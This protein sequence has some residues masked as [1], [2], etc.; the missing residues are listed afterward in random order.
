M[1]EGEKCIWRNAT[2]PEYN[3]DIRSDDFQ[4]HLV[5]GPAKVGTFRIVSAIL[6]WTAGENEI[7]CAHAL[8]VLSELLHQQLKV[9][10]ERMTASIVMP[11]VGT[12]IFVQI[13]V[14]LILRKEI[15]T[16]GDGIP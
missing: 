4:N 14:V 2:I 5:N 6:T 7:C 16:L 9:A 1:F 12:P 15:E 13:S 11:I 8:Q 10:L 3:D